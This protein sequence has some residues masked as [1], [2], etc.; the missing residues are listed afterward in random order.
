MLVMGFFLASETMAISVFVEVYSWL[1][2]TCMRGK[3]LSLKP[4]WSPIWELVI[5]ADAWPQ[6][7]LQGLRPTTEPNHTPVPHV[8]ILSIIIID[9]YLFNTTC[10]YY[11]M[12]RC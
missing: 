6:N 10:V 7:T 2:N 9:Y 11:S 12:P 3:E 1:R 8:T 4:G 5:S